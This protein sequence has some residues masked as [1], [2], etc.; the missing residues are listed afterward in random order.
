[1]DRAI[2][3]NPGYAEAYYWGGRI[4]HVLNKPEKYRPY[5]QH[6]VKIKPDSYNSQDLI[7]RYSHLLR[8]EKKKQ[9][10]PVQPVSEQ[11][12][13]ELDPRLF[14]ALVAVLLLCL[15]LLGLRMR[16]AKTEAGA[17]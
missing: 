12:R 4:Y 1:M 15:L 6:Y 9:A 3:L 7:K 13:P 11:V 5:F 16:R 2:A 8:D 10:Q 17:H 14:P